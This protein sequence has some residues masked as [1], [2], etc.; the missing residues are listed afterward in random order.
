M[1]E[2]YSDTMILTTAEGAPLLIHH[3]GPTTPT[4]IENGVVVTVDG[5][6]QLEINNDGAIAVEK[7]IPA[8]NGV[9]HGISRVLFSPDFSCG[10]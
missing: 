6:I 4:T 5:G 7:D 1:A 3:S 2:T 9:M 8:Y 10:S